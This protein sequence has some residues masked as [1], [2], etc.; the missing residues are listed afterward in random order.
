MDW[1]V[2]DPDCGDEFTMRSR[3]LTR[4]WFLAVICGGLLAFAAPVSAD[5]KPQT[6][7]AQTSK[8]KPVH[9]LA[10][11]SKATKH[12]ASSHASAAQSSAHKTKQRRSKARAKSK[13]RGQQ[14]IDSERAR[15]IQEALIREHYL[16][17]EP[18]GSWDNATQSAMRRYQADQGWQAKT[19]PDSRA[20]IK[21]GLGP[22][23][24]HLLNPESAMTSSV[25]SASSKADSKPND[26]D[27]SRS[28]TPSGDPPQQ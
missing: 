20:L 18:S 13:K 5:T 9:P 24:E 19:I 10:G 2:H 28:R 16:D 3:F 26:D 27:P 21:L 23:P 1:I 8:K 12:R 22:S 17:G 11:S 15:Q 4:N 7:T 14:A 6:P 25:V